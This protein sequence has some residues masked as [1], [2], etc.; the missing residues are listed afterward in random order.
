[1]DFRFHQLIRVRFAELRLD[2]YMRKSQSVGRHSG[3]MSRRVEPHMVEVM[4]RHS[5]INTKQLT[6]LVLV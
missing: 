1:M 6:G 3:D 5:V 2:R 4:R